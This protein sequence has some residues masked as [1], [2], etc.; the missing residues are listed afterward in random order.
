[1]KHSFLKGWWC[2]CSFYIPTHSI[3]YNDYSFSRNREKFKTFH[4]PLV[5]NH[6]FK[7]S[8]QCE[9]SLIE[10]KINS[11]VKIFLNLVNSGSK[12]KCRECRIVSNGCWKAWLMRSFS[13]EH[14]WRLAESTL[15]CLWKLCWYIWQRV[16]FSDKS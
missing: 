10:V 5:S 15:L 13:S 12:P 11:H 2:L 7:F 1:M 14:C 3:P 9:I 4:I 16:Q 6:H 8:R